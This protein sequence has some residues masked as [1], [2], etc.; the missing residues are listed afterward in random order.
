[1]VDELG[2]HAAA[3]ALVIEIKLAKSI[4]ITIEMVNRVRNKA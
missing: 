1:V 2:A 3:F 4:S